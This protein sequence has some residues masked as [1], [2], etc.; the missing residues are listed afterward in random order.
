MQTPGKSTLCVH[1]GE[2]DDP[3]T[4]GMTTPIFTASSFRYDSDGHSKEMFYPRYMNVPTQTAVAA[5]LARL[6][7]PAGGAEALM[8]NLVILAETAFQRAS[9]EKHRAGSVDSADGRF[10]PEMGSHV[11]Y[12]QLITLPARTSCRT[13][14]MD[15]P[16]HT[17][18]AGAKH[19]VPVGIGKSH[20]Q[21]R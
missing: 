20:F 3:Q 8:G 10:F 12:L 2:Y 13:S 19:A 11:R 6:E 7:S 15:G 9:A 14:T 1:A 17:A 5:K 16:V 21:N 4:G 18:A